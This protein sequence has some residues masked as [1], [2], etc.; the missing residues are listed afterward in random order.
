MSER[1]ELT[2]EELLER[3]QQQ[4]EQYKKEQSSK[5]KKKWLWG[6]GGC[7]IFVILMGIIFSACSATMVNSVDKE[8]NKDSAEVKKDANATR[9]QTAAL[10]SAKNYSDTLHMSKQGIYDQLTSEAGDKFSAEDAQYA[11]DYLKADYKENAV[12]SAENY[13]ETMNMNMS[14][15]AIYDQLKSDAGDKFT[16]EEARYGVDN[17]SK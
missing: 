4:F 15:D 5:S 7:L 14:D 12:K 16:P 17:M 11:I 3:Q 6:C 9:E 8:L 10:N 13:A 2:N 1:K